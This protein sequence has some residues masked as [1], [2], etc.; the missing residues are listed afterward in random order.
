MS[1]KKTRRGSGNGYKLKV[2]ILQLN[3]VKYFGNLSS[4]LDYIKDKLGVF[5]IKVTEFI[6]GKEYSLILPIKFKEEP[7]ENC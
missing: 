4:C 3:K 2:N 6:M 7:N 5:D 1:R